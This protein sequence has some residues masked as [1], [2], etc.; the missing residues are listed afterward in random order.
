[1]YILLEVCQ[2][3][4]ILRIIQFILIIM[5]VIFTIVPIG[6]ILM[7]L[8]DLSKVVISQDEQ[9]GP[10]TNKL[11]LQRIIMAIMIFMIPTIVSFISSVIDMGDY[12][13]CITNANSNTIAYYQS[14]EDKETEEEKKKEEKILAARKA[15]QQELKQ[16]EQS[17]NAE[18]SQS[19]KK[20]T[21]E[22]DPLAPLQNLYNQS[23]STFASCNPNNFK[24]MT[25]KTN[26]YSL[27]AWPKNAQTSNLTTIS[28]TYANGNLIYPITGVGGQGYEHNG[29]DIVAT[30]GTPIYSPVDG[31]ITFSEW[32][33]TVN[34][35]SSETA[36]S[37]LIKVDTPFSVQGTWQK[38]GNTTKK[39]GEVFLTHMVGINKRI[40]SSG[41]T[42]VKK[43]DF[44]GFSG[45]ANNCAH[46]HMTLYTTGEDDGLMSSSI[47]E[48]YGISGSGNTKKAG[49]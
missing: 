39:V 18:E 6:L 20:T 16:Q 47:K 44:L 25:D 19:S 31:T 37:V 35:G 15:K 21:N 7:L 33:H 2:T 8:I 48:I 14:I 4:G 24:R 49:E 38:G 22:P 27:G 17:I 26:G 28:K 13:S 1:M 5:D 30:V 12:S 11:I 42:K 41:Q 34:K 23:Q 29:I 43:G 3:P 10:K 32:G 40:T 9:A 36:Y 46:L 45:V